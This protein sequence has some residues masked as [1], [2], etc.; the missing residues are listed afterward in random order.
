[1]RTSFAVL[2]LLVVHLVS[3]VGAAAGV[4]VIIDPTGDGA[5]SSLNGPEHVT[6]DDAGNVYV[7]AGISR[8]AFKWEPDGTISEII[9]HS[10]GGHFSDFSLTPIGIAVDDAGNVFVSADDPGDPFSTPEDDAVFRIA[11]DGTLALVLDP[12]GAGLGPTSFDPRSL[13]TDAS[14]NVYVASNQRVFKLS[15]QG[16]V[17]V[18]NDLLLPGSAVGL[19]LDR[20]SGHVHTTTGSGDE[21]YSIFP[22]G[23]VDRILEPS[24]D[25]PYHYLTDL[26]VDGEGNVFVCNRSYGGVIRVAPD[27][28]VQT[29]WPDPLGSG[30]GGC[31]TIV[32]DAA[33]DVYF[34]SHWDDSVVKVRRD[35]SHS[36][37]LSAAGD[38]QGN[39]LLNPAGVAVDASGNV[40]VASQ[41]TSRVFRISPD[42][43][44]GSVPDGADQSGPPLTV[45]RVGS[46]LLL[47]WG[48]SCS[49]ED[50][51]FAVYR[52]EL[53][54]F[55]SH[56][57]V[58]CETGGLTEAT[59]PL[60]PDDM[61]YLVAP[62]NGEY[63][64]SVGTRGDGTQRP[65]S[66]APC[67]VR[68]YAPC[69]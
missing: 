49:T 6:V 59:V 61:Y 8:N 25:I 19:A 10:G 16:T 43:T 65:S 41:G 11:P 37:I 40:Y 69:S 54:Q 33:G 26:T 66:G 57:P 67:F 38:G 36:E 44:A 1:M 64:G 22:S 58:N 52:G 46:E 2:L 17:T 13:T 55:D 60:P 62:H 47:Q 5:G 15:P 7:T 53:G 68:A 28:A 45:T 27:G 21:V 50:V 56:A 31:R 3:S 14:G 34:S 51:E 63:E 32:A 23:A 30:G 29:V 48:P 18:I 24:E 4:D 12:A 20:T 9:D 42:A 35:G 39:S